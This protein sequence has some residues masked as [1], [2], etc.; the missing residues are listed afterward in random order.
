M[1]ATVLQGVGEINVM[2][3][4]ER[5][6]GAGADQGQMLRH[7]RHRSAYLSRPHGVCGRPPADRAG[8]RYHGEAKAK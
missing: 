8:P 5:P 6:L 1:K 3:W 4:P 2:E 7:M